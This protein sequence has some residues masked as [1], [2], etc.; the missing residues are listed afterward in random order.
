MLP[1]GQ[2][3]RL[4]PIRVANAEMTELKPGGW[5]LF[6]TFVRTPETHTAVDFY[7]LSGELRAAFADFDVLHDEELTRVNGRSGQPK[8]TAQLVARKPGD[9]D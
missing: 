9:L 3:I 6:E 8:S 1:V 7:L 5:L 2:A 4:L